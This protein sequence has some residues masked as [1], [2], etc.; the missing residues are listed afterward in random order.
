LSPVSFRDNRI[1]SREGDQR[2]L[3]RAPNWIG[4]QV[5]AYP[6]FYFLRK[7]YPNAHI[8]VACVSWVQEL[9]FLD[10]VDEVYVLSRPT[11]DSLRDKIS[12]IET[13][14]R[15]LKKKVPYDLSFTLPNSISSAWLTFRAGSKRRRG[16]RY[17]GRGLLLNEATPWPDAQHIVHRAQAYVELLPEAAKPKRDIQEFWGILPEN[18]LD[19]A[20]PGELKEFDALKSWPDYAPLEP[21]QESYWVLAPG[22]TAD[23]RRWPVEYFTSLA[24]KVHQETGW[25]GVIVGG[26]K[27][28]P[29]AAKLCSDERLHLVDMTAR[30]PVPVLSKIFKNARFTVCNESGLAHVASFCGSFTQIVC[31]AAD[32]RRT[33]PLGPGRVQVAINPVECWPCEKNTCSQLPEKKFQCLR[34]IQPHSV[35]EE[36]HR[37]LKR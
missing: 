32:P 16:Y 28:A 27:E 19:Q 36:I 26:P 9:Q 3:V 34:G 11:T 25:K 37:G 6:F 15:S 24:E 35:W 2:I 33:Q 30:G 21:P 31:G 18:D 12:I 13:D 22:A 7:A 4:D 23:S 8:T 17:E 14:A 10:L 29:L 20:I 5:L 1:A